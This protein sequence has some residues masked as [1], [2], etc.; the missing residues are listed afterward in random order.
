MTSL[1]FSGAPFFHAQEGTRKQENAILFKTP[2]GKSFCAL[3]LG[4]G[5]VFKSTPA[6]VRWVIDN[7]GCG[8]GHPTILLQHGGVFGP[9]LMTDTPAVVTQAAARTKEIVVVAGGHWGRAASSKIARVNA[10]NDRKQFLLYSNWQ[11]VA[12]HSGGD[13]SKPNGA[14]EAY[15]GGIYY[16]VLRIDPVAKQVSSWDWS[17]YWRSRKMVGSDTPEV[18]T[19]TLETSYDLDA[20]FP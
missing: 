3:N 12:I 15:S 6:E 13:A 18:A 19:S 4:E 16:T 14:T 7:V 9:Q 5:I 11:E 8:G 10:L 17:P 2:T 20:V 1:E